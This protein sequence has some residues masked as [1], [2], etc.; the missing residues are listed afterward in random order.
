MTVSMS[1][2]P[3]TAPSA[4]AAA[5][6]EA[7]AY[8]RD[9]YG[10]RSD[11]WLAAGLLTRPNFFRA[12]QLDQA[13]AFM[14]D[15][16]RH[17][18]VYHSWCL[19]AEPPSKG[20]GTAADM[21]VVPGI[22]LD[23]DLKSPAHMKTDL[24]NT[25]EEFLAFMIEA[26]LPLPT[27]VRN[28]GNGL[29]MDY[30]FD[31]PFVIGGDKDRKSI[32]STLKA[33]T[34]F[35]IEAALTARGW[36]LDDCSDLPR[37]TRMPGTWNHKTAPPKPVLITDLGSG[38]R[39]SVEKAQQIIADRN[40][41][42]SG[43][44]NRVAGKLRSASRNRED[45]N[46][47]EMCAV[48][49]GCAAMRYC[50]QEAASLPEP[51]WH[52]QASVASRVAGG[53]KWFLETSAVYPEFKLEEA[54]TKFDRAVNAPGPIGCVVI[55]DD[56]GCGACEGCP[57]RGNVS[58]PAEF[59]RFSPEYVK[60]LRDTVVVAKT[61]QF[62]DRTN[63]LEL[64]A[65]AFDM[66][67][68]HAVDHPSA[69]T[70]ESPLSTKVD[71]PT[72]VPGAP[73]RIVNFEDGTTGLNRWSP[74][75]LVPQEGSYDLIKQHFEVVFEDDIEREH[76]LDVIA[77]LVQKPGVK[78]HHCAVVIGGEG[79]GK[80]TIGNIIARLVGESNSRTVENDEIKSPYQEGLTD[81]VLLQINE[82][83]GFEQL[84]AANRLK[85]LLTEETLRARRLYQDY[86][87]KMTPRFIFA[88]SNHDLPT[89][90]GSSARRHFVSRSTQPRLSPEYFKEFY[91][92]LPSEL[93]AFLFAML[94]RDISRF[95]PKAAPPTTAAKV[96]LV[97][98]SRPEAE[99]LLFRTLE[100]GGTALDR[101]VFLRAELV[102]IL[103][104][105]LSR[106]V[107]ENDVSNAI[108]FLKAEKLVQIRFAG[109]VR[110]R[111]YAHRNIEK[112]KEANPQEVRGEVT[113]K[114]D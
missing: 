52:A 100:D 70:T 42:R 81:T 112:W 101:D 6:V 89:R 29:Y 50:E 57:F 99:Q 75:T 19:L 8:L 48:L 98:A 13:A 108:A 95:N 1:L 105:G 58:G 62:I 59:S 7:V 28:S 93:P 55:A 47:P 67:H 49:E 9:L 77:H 65:K 27:I 86:T 21:L 94:Q 15:L 46:S 33:F 63:F 111:P 30:R 79:T 107:T 11:G 20:R 88:T 34:R 43:S 38:D 44:R 83:K 3:L 26:S 69:A 24:P 80:T 39:I 64:D 74:T 37:V 10:T 17:D 66:K 76:M 5:F 18:H 25:S 73:A 2:D 78:I 54:E 23:I 96:F 106:R 71:Y 56:R 90:A 91:D 14:L 32:A 103:Q 102:D 104:Y 97:E 45:E 109:N 12:D 53:R 68:A 85:G 22:M 36:D 113:R 4:D 84:E 40:G 51:L 31:E 72:Y 60:L 41:S 110:Q 92:A 61:H 114:I 35:I 87:E 82:L 16:G